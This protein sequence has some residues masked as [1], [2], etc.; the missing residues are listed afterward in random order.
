MP[1]FQSGNTNQIA[2]FFTPEIQRWNESIQNWAAASNLDPNMVATVMQ[3]ESCGD[4]LALSPAGAMGLFQVMPYHFIAVD[5]PYDPDT[6]ARRGLEYLRQALET[7]SGNTRLAFAGYN[8]GIAVINRSEFTWA[9]ET[10]RY[11]YWANGIYADAARDAS[12]SPRL[13]EWLAT[14]G[15]SLCRQAR[16]RL[17][18]GE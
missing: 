10:Q 3:I 7:S 8:G 6:N 5:N 4:P 13:Q 12:E 9:A 15:S 16:Q 14:G 1:V 17:G 11:A 18:F 2:I